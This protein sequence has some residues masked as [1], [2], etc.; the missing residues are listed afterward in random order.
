MAAREISRPCA[1]GCGEIV[2]STFRGPLACGKGDCLDRYNAAAEAQQ[3]ETSRRRSEAQRNRKPRTARPLYG[4]Y[5]QLAAFFGLATD[6]TGRK[7]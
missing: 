2:T 3:A 4:D 5:A 1:Y 7:N 6:G